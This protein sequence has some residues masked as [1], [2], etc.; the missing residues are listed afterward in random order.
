[1]K[2]ATELQ[3]RKLA[4]ILT[5]ILVL[6]LLWSGLRLLL[7]SEPDPIY[8]AEASLRVDG[9]LYA[10]QPGGEL[11][12]ALVSRPL[13]WQDRSAYVPET[14]EEIEEPV[15]SRGSEAINQVKLQGVYNTGTVPGIIISYGEE[16]RRMRLGESVEG[17]K[18]IQLLPEGA[19]F[20]SG[21]E[22]RTLDL[23]HALSGPKPVEDTAAD[24]PA[25]GAKDVSGAGN[26]QDSSEHNETTGE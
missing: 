12:R 8:P 13:F 15:D 3:L 5:A 1:M 9:I 10:A 26:K 24:E 18:F 7:T 19:V 22:K 23:E 16:R 21:E 4:L 14:H 17:W 6:Q 2:S 25:A 11:S 20:R